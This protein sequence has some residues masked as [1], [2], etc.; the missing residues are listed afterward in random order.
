[1]HDGCVDC[2]ALPRLHELGPCFSETFAT[3]APNGMQVHVTL[4]LCLKC[5]ARFEDRSQLR[6]YL[7][8][9][10]PAVPQIIA[11]A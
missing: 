7:R 2:R 5:G 6:E 9:R 10:M 8:S 4:C 1:L 3:K 11:A